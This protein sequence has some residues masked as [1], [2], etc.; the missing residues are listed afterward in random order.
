[1]KSK[2]ANEPMIRPLMA[3]AFAVPEVFGFLV[4]SGGKKIVVTC[5][6]AAPGAATIHLVSPKKTFGES[7]MEVHE[8]TTFELPALPKYEYVKRAALSIEPPT[9]VETWALQLSLSAVVQHRVSI[10]VS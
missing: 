8:S 7:D 5:T 9:T 10:E 2:V 3:Y 6:L 4:R 1:M